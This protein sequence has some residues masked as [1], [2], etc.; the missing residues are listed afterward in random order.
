[1]IIAESAHSLIEKVINFAQGCLRPG[2][3]SLWLYHTGTHEGHVKN[4]M[5]N[6]ELVVSK[7]LLE[8]ICLLGLL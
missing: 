8:F 5:A 3:S 7:R 6:D 4:Y 1:M 2:G